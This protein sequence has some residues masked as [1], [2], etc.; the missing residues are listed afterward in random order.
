MDVNV[1]LTGGT[2]LVMHNVRLADKL[3]EFAHQ[4]ALINAKK[5]KKTDADDAA[6]A[7]L[8]WRGGIYH[9]P[10]IGVYVP[11]WNVVKC[12]NQA[13]TVTRRGKDVYRA[14]LFET[15]KLR[16]GHDGPAD[17]EALRARPEY[18]WRTSVGIGR[19]TVTR[20]RPI[21]R[22]WSL[23][24]AG[25]LLEDVMDPEDFRDIVQLAGRSEGLGDARIMGYGRFTAEVT[26]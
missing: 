15:D 3:D 4:I 5:S 23:T 12:F 19:S 20:I 24:L 13:A 9:D 26:W 18:R 14:F 17:I 21:F 6:I 10:E 2:P 22:K 16:L 7:E 25:T 11:T 8:E 1:I